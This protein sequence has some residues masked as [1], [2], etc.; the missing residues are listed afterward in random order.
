MLAGC[1]QTSQSGLPFMPFISSG[2]PA[3]IVALGPPQDLLMRPVANQLAG[4]SIS[5]EQRRNGTI[6]VRTMNGFASPLR[7]L[8]PALVRPDL[9]PFLFPSCE[10]PF[11]PASIEP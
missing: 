1:L 8:D 9:I 3:G 11:S 2:P 10:V 6:L 7:G 5:L 4:A